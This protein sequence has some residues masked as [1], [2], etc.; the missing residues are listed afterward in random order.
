[1]AESREEW[2]APSVVA[3]T[4]LWLGRIPFAPGT[5]GAVAGVVVSLATGALATAIA[6]RASSPE[7][8]VAIEAVILVVLNL[9]AI[10][11]CSAAAPRIGRGSDPG[12]IVL[13][14][15]LSLPLGMLVVPFAGRTLPVIVVGWLLHRIFD[16][17]KPFPCRRLEHL[18]RGLGVMADDWGAAAWMAAALFAWRTSGG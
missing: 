9:V 18:P 10:P 3:A 14:E 16:V 6:E 2:T 4:C 1:M 17:S 13:D 7:A 5:W 8:A 12:P 11:V 15:A